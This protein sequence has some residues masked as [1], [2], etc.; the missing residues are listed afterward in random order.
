MSKRKYV[1]VLNRTGKKQKYPADFY[2][3]LCEMFK[4][5]FNEYK[6]IDEEIKSCFGYMP[7]IKSQKNMKRAITATYL[8]DS[9]RQGY[10]LIRN[11]RKLSKKEKAEYD[12][13]DFADE[14]FE[15][16]EGKYTYL[17]FIKKERLVKYLKGRVPDGEFVHT[18]LDAWVITPQ[19]K[20]ELIE[21]NKKMENK[22]KKKQK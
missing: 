12:S 3:Q 11:A 4:D 22:I 14:A 5:D 16:V 20:K 7:E 19:Q 17:P 15:H 6:D 21:L 9:M 18:E 8:Y 1:Y 10:C 13:S 2:T